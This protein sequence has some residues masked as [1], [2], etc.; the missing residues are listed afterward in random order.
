[1]HSVF[2]VQGDATL[3]VVRKHICLEE[4]S[5]GIATFH[6]KLVVCHLRQLVSLLL[7]V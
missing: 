5:E 1:M 6:E 3:K 4:R 2:Y 7:Y